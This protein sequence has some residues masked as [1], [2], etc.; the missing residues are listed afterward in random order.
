MMTMRPWLA[1]PL[2]RSLL[3]MAMLTA[4]QTLLY[5]AVDAL[6]ELPSA[7]ADRVVVHTPDG[8]ERV[9]RDPASV[10]RM[11]TFA[12]ER[13]HGWIHVSPT[14]DFF[15]D[16]YA[17]FYRGGEMRGW[18]SWSAWSLSAPTRHASATYPL[19]PAERAELR[20]LLETAR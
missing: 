1:R 12:R 14:M 3:M 4:S 11:V 16:T 10:A 15:N 5:R 13:R 8:A 20:R 17:R 18:I 9:I 2:R 7:D 6:P 19:P